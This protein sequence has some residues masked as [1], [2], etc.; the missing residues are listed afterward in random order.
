MAGMNEEAGMPHAAVGVPSEAALVV[1]DLTLDASSGLA[2]RAGA[3]V[4]LNTTE[5]RV[6][7]ALL[8]HPN[9][10][11]TTESLSRSVWGTVTPSSA[12][13]LALYIRCLQQKLE[14]HPGTPRFLRA[15]RG[16]YAV[17]TTP[18]RTRTPL[19]RLALRPVL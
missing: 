9:E 1:G 8:A 14:A 15:V 3:A 18:A 13:Y 17:R 11:V 7:G 6:L 2:W 4:E 12:A 16:G 19:P 10:T 5:R